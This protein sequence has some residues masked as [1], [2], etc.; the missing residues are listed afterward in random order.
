M[1]AFEAYGCSAFV[2]QLS[3]HAHTPLR[4]LGVIIH[5]TSS[6]TLHSTYICKILTLIL[7]C[8]G[9]RYILT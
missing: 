4:F 5:R 6:Y 9:T 7:V 3:L 2:E 8:C 1:L